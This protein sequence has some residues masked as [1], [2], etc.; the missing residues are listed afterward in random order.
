[1]DF[2]YLAQSNVGKHLSLTFWRHPTTHNRDSKYPK[3]KQR[4]NAYILSTCYKKIEGLCEIET[5]WKI[6]YLVVRDTLM[7]Y[8]QLFIRNSHFLSHRFSDPFYKV[9]WKQ[10]LYSKHSNLYLVFLEI[11]SEAFI[12]HKSIFWWFWFYTYVSK[13]LVAR[14]LSLRS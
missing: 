13:T 4:K 2:E 12:Y 10:Y 8:F 3:K 11:K 14:L 6:S 9:L 7:I 1:M 5:E